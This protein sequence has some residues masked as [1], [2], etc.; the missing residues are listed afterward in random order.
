MF[1]IISK[2]VSGKIFKGRSI[3]TKVSLLHHL[4]KVGWNALIQCRDLFQ[5]NKRT[6]AKA[7][8]SNIFFALSIVER[9]NLIM[10]MVSMMILLIVL[11]IFQWIL[12]M[13]LTMVLTIVLT[14]ALTMVLIMVLVKASVMFL[15]VILTMMMV[16]MCL[17][18]SVCKCRPAGVRSTKI[19]SRWPAINIC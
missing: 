1:A 13:I 3:F 11:M 18:C 7:L 10:V 2:N 5:L 6:F 9:M 15:M 16:V 8:F 12:T 14:M 4:L 19:Q 17:T